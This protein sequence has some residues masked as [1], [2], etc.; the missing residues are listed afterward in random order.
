MPRFT[1][2]NFMLLPTMAC[3]AGCKYCF[4]KKSGEVMSR[5]TADRAIDFIADIAP[6]GEAIHLTFHG[7]EPLLAGEEFYAYI[8]PRLFERFGRRVNLSIQTNLWEMTD[9]LAE[10]FR[11]YRVAV[12][13]SVDGAKEMCDSQRGE[14]YYDKTAKGLEMLKNHRMGAG[15][16][17]TFG[18]QNA[19]KAAQVYIESKSPY[20]IH[21]AVQ[22][23]GAPQND[24]NVSAG[25]MKQILLDSYEAYRADPSH[26]RITTIDSMIKG[27]FK[28]RGCTCTFFDCLGAF[29]AIAPDGGVYSCQRF[30]GMDEYCLGNI[31]DG[32]TEQDILESPAYIRLRETEDKK[33]KACGDCRHFSY[34]MG[35]CLYNTLAAESEKDPHCEAYMALYNKSG[36]DMALEMG[37]IM[38]GRDK[39][40]PVLAMAGDQPHPFKKRVSESRIKKAVELGKSDAPYSALYLRDPYPENNLNK[41]Y[42]HLTFACPLRCPHCYAEGG[43]NKTDELYAEQ[44]A[45]IVEEAADRAFRSVVI[46]GGEPLVYKDF[47]RLCELLKKIDRKG[48]Q[49]VLRSSFGFPIDDNVMKTICEVFDEIVVSVDGDKSTHD[50][51]R[52]NGRYDLT[53]E[54]LKK[55]VNLGAAQKLGLAATLSREQTEGEA[56]ESVH[57]LA[58]SLNIPKTRFRPVLPLGRGSGAKQEPYQLCSEEMSVPED[59]YLRHTCGLGQN[60][61]VRPDGEAYPC[62]AW[63]ESDKLLGKL[64]EEPLGALLDRGEL[65]SYC[66]H[67]VD[68][69]EKCRS[70]EVRYL[71]GG[72][73]KAWVSDR[74]N[75][76]SGDFDC[77]ERKK[78]FT[79]LTN[80]L[81]DK[82]EEY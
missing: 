47:D 11:K 65:F 55:A 21:G 58:A 44:F 64:G 82:K 36:F 57:K 35:G 12:G 40:T 5:E 16:I 25:Q 46:T 66:A 27:Q 15:M 45:S 72:I 6:K 41:L 34:C 19:G 71:C 73:C 31:S 9:T 17:C 51:R 10:L 33:Q 4:A 3:Q 67:D 79:R 32:L 43:E 74:K 14:G 1:P 28:E 20:S 76:D 49:L 59:F 37:D 29:A 22:T 62:Y 30:C 2:N 7:G 8:L 70:C 56:G 18:A 50:A 80:N 68:S 26:S 78:Y 53:V 81:R 69:N 60:L 42:L 75:I 63:C 23:I 52:G 13:T 54:N 39:G 24:M 61:Y 38:L 48:T 77:T